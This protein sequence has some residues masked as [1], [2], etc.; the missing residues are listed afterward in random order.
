M[1]YAKRREVLTATLAATAKG[2]GN[3]SDPH[4]RTGKLHN[5]V[6]KIDFIAVCP[7]SEPDGRN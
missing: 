4:G 7:P 3:V 2:R 5:R 6:G 1:A